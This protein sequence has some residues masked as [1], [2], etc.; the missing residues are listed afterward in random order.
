[1]NEPKKPTTPKTYGFEAPSTGELKLELKKPNEHPNAL[2]S[3]ED[4]VNEDLI[5]RLI[6]RLKKM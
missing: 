6:N 1:M 4:C 5:Q 3:L 2:Q